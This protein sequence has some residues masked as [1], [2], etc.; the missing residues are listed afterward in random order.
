[1]M[2]VIYQ[3]IGYAW[4]IHVSRPC[5]ECAESWC[6]EDADVAHVD[7]QVKRVEDVIN[8]TARGHQTGIDGSADNTPERIPCCRIEPVPKNLQHR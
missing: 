1:M 8:N 7:G 6:K 5:C 2:S 4:T 3:P